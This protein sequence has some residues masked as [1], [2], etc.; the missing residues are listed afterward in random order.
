[1]A[2]DEPLHKSLI[3]DTT[4]YFAYCLLVATLGSFQFGFHLVCTT[5]QLRLLP[6]T[7]L[8]LV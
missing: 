3:R 6:L 4:A 2:R 7:I 1:M 8:L 5:K